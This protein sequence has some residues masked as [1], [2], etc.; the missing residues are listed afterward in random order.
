MTVKHGKT[1]YRLPFR[2][3]EKGK[4]TMNDKV[5]LLICTNSFTE[6]NIAQ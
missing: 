5:L 6:A 4:A 1:I 2:F 3:A